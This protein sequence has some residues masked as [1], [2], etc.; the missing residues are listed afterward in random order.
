MVFSPTASYDKETEKDFEGTHQIHG[1][2]LLLLAYRNQKNCTAAMPIRL[3][4]QLTQTKNFENPTATNDTYAI[5][6][7]FLQMP[8]LQIYMERRSEMS[9]HTLNAWVCKER[10]CI[11]TL[12]HK[13]IGSTQPL[14]RQRNYHR[15]YIHHVAENNSDTL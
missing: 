7:Y 1:N 12:F 6:K 14:I 3:H 5:N 4:V 9:T 10:I 2:A 8:A 15:E 13:L 11:Q